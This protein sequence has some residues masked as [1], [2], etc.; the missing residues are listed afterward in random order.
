MIRS[1]TSG[2]QPRNLSLDALK[3]VMAM[4]V[5][6][7]HAG[8]LRDVHPGLSHFFTNGLFRV[9]VP[10]FLVINGYFLERQLDQGLGA[11]VRRVALLYG[12]WMA[13][14]A[15]LWL[16]GALAVPS[17]GR[18]VLLFGYYHLWYLLALLLGG[19]LV[20]ALRP[21]GET[22]LVAVGALTFAAGVGIQYAGNLHLFDGPLDQS[23][24]RVHT[25]RNFLF[26]GVPFLICGV[27]VARHEGRLARLGSGR[28]LALALGLLAAE[29]SANMIWNRD[30]PV[31]EIFVSLAIVCPVLFLT[32]KG[33]QL[34]G[35]SRSLGQL[36][37]ALYLVHVA[38]LHF[39]YDVE[40]GDTLRTLV[41]LA[42]GSLVAVPV[43]LAA[44]RV[45]L[46]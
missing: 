6:G 11:W 46:L 23:L 42:I 18:E 28:M 13:I 40:M 12:L 34:R 27:L 31:F 37:T 45:P 43:V 32:V 38:V 10:T 4:M 35:T 33:W 9:A 25:Y 21:A 30:D 8:F 36:A 5:V 14:Y 24:N 39:T 22:V 29:W 7:L 15:P 2:P 19:L 20:A 26:M 3:I 1:A 16:P 41:G 17:F 44:R